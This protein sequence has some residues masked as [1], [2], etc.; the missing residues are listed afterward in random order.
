MKDSA[1]ME[2][3]WVKIVP[4]IVDTVLL[5]SAIS[6][7][8]VLSQYP[9][10]SGWLTE[11]VIGLVMYIGLGLVALKLGATKQ[12]KTAAFIGAIAVIAVMG[13]LAVTKQ[14]FLF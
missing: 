5:V 3:K 6:L 1:M 13:K 8:I 2:K 10:T 4:H 7:C 11:K 9:G 12:I 14:P